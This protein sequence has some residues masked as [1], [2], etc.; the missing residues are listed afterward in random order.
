MKGNSKDF[1]NAKR[2]DLSTQQATL[3]TN[4]NKKK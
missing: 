2:Q 4:V 3:K 1:F